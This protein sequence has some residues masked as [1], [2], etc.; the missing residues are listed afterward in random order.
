MPAEHCPLCGAARGAGGCA[1]HSSVPRS[2]DETVVLPQMEGP[3]LVRPYVPAAVHYEP[4]SVPGP[5]GAGPSGAG[6]SGTGPSGTDPFATAV[7]PPVQA[8]PEPGY[9]HW[10]PAPPPPG[11]PD[12]G[13]YSVHAPAAAGPAPERVRAAATRRRAAV[14]G[15]G[16][17]IVALGAGLALALAPSDKSKST[18]HALPAPSASAPD[19]ATPSAVPSVS[20]SAASSPSAKPSPSPSAS[21]SSSRPPTSAAPSSAAPSP[22]PSPSAPSPSAASPTPSPSPTVRAVLQ[23]GDKGADVTAMQQRLVAVLDWAYDD[24]LVTG[25]FDNR[26]KQAV[27]Y[28]QSV[29]GQNIPSSE[30]GGKYGPVTR[31]QL[32]SMS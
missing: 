10:E 3:P 22:S 17:G 30:R 31:S 18:D 11:R 14:V 24:S 2:A 23:Q 9:P 15:A 27:S 4:S 13:S 25:T 21:R 20:A 28:F 6:P 1:C 26:T 29:Y 8:G 7:L 5:S 12:L 16:L 19:S 32:E